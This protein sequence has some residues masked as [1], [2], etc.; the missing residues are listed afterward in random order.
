MEREKRKKKRRGG[1]AGERGKE[2][3][4]EKLEGRTPEQKAGMLEMVVQTECAW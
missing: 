3:Q 4:A 1:E 2:I